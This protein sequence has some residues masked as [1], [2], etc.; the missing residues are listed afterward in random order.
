[1][2][3]VQQRSDVSEEHRA[4]ELLDLIGAQLRAIGGSGA[5]GLTVT[6]HVP[7]DLQLYIDGNR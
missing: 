7:S 6:S 1:M 4:L 3:K 5:T 2:S